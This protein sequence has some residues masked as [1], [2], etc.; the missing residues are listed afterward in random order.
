MNTRHIPV[1]IISTEE[2]RERGLRMGAV[3]VLTKPVRT[4]ETLDQTFEHLKTLLQPRTRNVLV[5]EADDARRTEISDL[6]TGEDVKVFAV[7]TGDAALE[8]LAGNTYDA[9]VLDVDLPD[10]KGFDLVD[11]MRE[12]ADAREL[13]ILF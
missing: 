13:P 6:L 3:G 9:A 12:R 7:A 10:R 1:Q 5:V 8:A 11:E 2:E 4:K